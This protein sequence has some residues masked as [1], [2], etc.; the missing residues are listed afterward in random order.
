MSPALRRAAL[1]LVA[2]AAACAL[3]VSATVQLTAARIA[4]QQQR[5]LQRQLAEVLTGVRYDAL[6][7]DP[8]QPLPDP[9]GGNAPARQFT[10]L[11]A[12]QPVARLLD[13]RTP[14]G[15]GGDIRLLIGIAVDGRV[16]GVR[17]LEHRETPGLGD[18]IELRRSRWITGFAGRALGDPAE[19]GWALR[20]D[21]GVYDAFTGASITPRAVV[22]AVRDALLWHA[23]VAGP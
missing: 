12:G 10:A 20:A 16:T 4:A 1:A 19:Q 6:P 9:C 11:L 18:L 5:A 7:T 17:V 21:G 3:A 2:L 8:P 13:C 14:R 15:Y 23:A 22:Q